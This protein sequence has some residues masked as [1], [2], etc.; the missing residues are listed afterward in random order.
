MGF[1]TKVLKNII[2][3]EFNWYSLWIIL[4]FM[5]WSILLIMDKILFIIDHVLLKKKIC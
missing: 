5:D 2:G 3:H 1:T 4:F